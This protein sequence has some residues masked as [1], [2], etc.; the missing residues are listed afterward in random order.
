MVFMVIINYFDKIDAKLDSLHISREKLVSID[1]FI[2]FGK[3]NCKAKKKGR[4]DKHQYKCTPLF[5]YCEN[6]S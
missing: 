3:I 6:K 2:Y 1:Y 4:K 5:H